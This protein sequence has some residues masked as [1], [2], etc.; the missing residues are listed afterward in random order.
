M[1]KRKSRRETFYV[2]TRAGRR[3][4]E[5]DYW[6]FGEAEERAAKLRA[7]LKGWRDKDYNKVEII[8]TSDPTEIY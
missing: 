5:E 4:E 1:K 8:K 7:C 6:T 3:I 2:V